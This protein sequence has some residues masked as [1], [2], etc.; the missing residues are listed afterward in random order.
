MQTNDLGPAG[1]PAAWKALEDHQRQMRD[2]SLRDLFA[3]DP[4]RGRRLTVEAAG[5]FLDYSKN[6]VTDETLNLLLRPRGAGGL[7]RPDRRH[8]PGREDQRDGK[9]GG[10]A[11][12]PARAGGASIIVDGKNVVPEVQ[13]VL[14]RMTDF[15]ERVRDGALEGPHRQAHAQRHQYR[16]R[17]LRPRASDGL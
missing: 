2:V 8:V 12:G 6:R 10:P 11:C 15:S 16:H 17:R 5:V 13:A 1:K 9:P 3:G 4:E 14:A 7:A